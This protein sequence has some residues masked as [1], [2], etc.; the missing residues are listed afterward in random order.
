MRHTFFSVNK[1]VPAEYVKSMGG[2]GKDFDTFGTYGHE[3][4]GEAE[5]TAMLVNDAITKL[6]N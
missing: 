5:K 2:H 6:I 3:M 1:T 4:K